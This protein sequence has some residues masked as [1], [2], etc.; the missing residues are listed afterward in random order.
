MI[1]YF[2]CAL[3]A[4]LKKPFKNC[5]STGRSMDIQVRLIFRAK[6]FREKLLRQ[7]THFDAKKFLRT[8]DDFLHQ[9]TLFKPK[10]FFTPKKFFLSQK[11]FLR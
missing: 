7:K 11:V 5:H 1:N 2:K 3:D 4:L 9:K 8:K 10:N 6:I